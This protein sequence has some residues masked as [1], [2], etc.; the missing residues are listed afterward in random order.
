MT[1]HKPHAGELVVG[2]VTTS[3]SSLLDVF[4]LKN[5]FGSFGKSPFA[6]LLSAPLAHSPKCPEHH[7]S[8]P[9]YPA[10]P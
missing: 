10:H 6:A 9:E 2:W 1:A 8:R 3:E 4:V 5:Y 7:Y